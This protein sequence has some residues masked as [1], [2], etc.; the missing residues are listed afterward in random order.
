[1]GVR[2]TPDLDTLNTFLIC[3]IADDSFIQSDPT[4][5]FTGE[6]YLV[7]WSDEKYG[8]SNAY[9][10]FAARVSPAGV[11]LDS[12]V[13][14]ST[15]SAYEYRPNVAD[16]GERSLVVWSGS[17]NGSYGRFVNREGLPEDGAFQIAPGTASGPNL[18]FGDSNYL[19]VW[20]QGTYPALQLYGNLVS[21]Q[22]DLVGSTIPIAADGGCHRWANVAYDGSRFLAVW[23][24]GENNLPETIF[25]QFIAKDGSLLGGRFPVSGTSA[26][27][28]WWP[29]LAFSDSN[30]LV[31]WEQGTS[32]DVY[33]NVDVPVAGIA[34]PPQ[35]PAAREQPRPSIA[36]SIPYGRALVYDALGRR[37][38][39]LKPGVYFTR[40]SGKTG[41][42]IRVR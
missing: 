18:C 1:M 32:R 37:S 31:V 15:S 26:V 7:V 17:S 8:P 6:N 28:R 34:E 25:G 27:Q 10:P 41:K 12:G 11:V 3:N 40:E 9:H 42:A 21:R 13:R 23:M 38:E 39:A 2:V 20:H 35:A 30:C 24:S 36:V 19:V 33:G 5:T 14:V 16:D 22:G 4:V 29:A